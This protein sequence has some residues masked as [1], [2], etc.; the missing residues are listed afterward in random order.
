MRFGVWGQTNPLIIARLHENPA[1]DVP[2]L[3]KKRSEED[4]AARLA[5]DFLQLILGFHT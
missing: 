5:N 4:E 3:I 1:S 2:E